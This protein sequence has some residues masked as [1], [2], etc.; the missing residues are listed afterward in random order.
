M[1]MLATDF[2]FRPQER[3]GKVAPGPAIDKT[4]WGYAIHD[5]LPRQ[6]LAAI[7]AMAGRFVGT[8]L[9]LAA[10]GLVVLPDGAHGTGIFGMKLAATVMFALFGAA[11]LIA[12][13]QAQHPEIQIDTSRARIRVGRRGLKGDFHLS[14]TLGF[15][16][17]ASVYLL[18]TKDR[19]QPARLF[20]RLA[21]ADAAIEVT[22]G[23]EA[24]LDALR[25][26]L[27]RDL[28]HDPRQP[29]ETLLRRHASVVA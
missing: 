24:E 19:S 23:P 16:D 15:D 9:L 1:A 21:A 5:R 10:A 6:G 13:R 18:R 8:I 25:L 3:G 26:T 20:L 29:V 4:H 11:F 12:G 22:S 17:V 28:A 7:G 14:A 27:T 2:D